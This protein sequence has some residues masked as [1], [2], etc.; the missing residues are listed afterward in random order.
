[1]CI[2][3]ILSRNNS[4]FAHK[5]AL[6]IMQ[7]LI[8]LRLICIKRLKTGIEGTLPKEKIPSEMNIT[9]YQIHG[10]ANAEPC[11]TDLHGRNKE[12]RP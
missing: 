8:Y 9:L 12:V 11:I 3:H 5:K 7:G 4:V 6:Q 2:Y 10:H 1:M